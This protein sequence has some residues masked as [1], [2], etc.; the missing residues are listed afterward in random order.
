MKCLRSVFLLPLL[1]LIPWAACLAQQEQQSQLE[2]C[3]TRDQL[4]NILDKPICTPVQPQTQTSPQTQP[5]PQRQSR[6]KYGKGGE[7][8]A[9]R[10]FGVVGYAFEAS[11]KLTASVSDFASV[12]TPTRGFN[13]GFI[14]PTFNVIDFF[15]LIG[16]FDAA[17]HQE[18]IA[19]V[20]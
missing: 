8:G 12:S 15:S 7:V 18:N 11:R 10:V 4:G 1:F 20:L 6:M 13:G 19:G 3:I 16:H 9:P 2:N 14:Q 17:Y 5:L